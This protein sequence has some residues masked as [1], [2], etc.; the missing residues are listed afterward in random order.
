MEYIL[1]KQKSHQIKN[2]TTSRFN[3]DSF[4]KELEGPRPLQEGF[5]IKK[6]KQ[7]SGCEVYSKKTETGS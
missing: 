4:L 6:R 1:N 7:H 3:Y 5:I 2:N